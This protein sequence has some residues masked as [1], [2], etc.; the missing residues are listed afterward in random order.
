MRLHGRLPA[1]GLAVSVA[2]SLASCQTLGGSKGSPEDFIRLKEG[3]N[4]DRGR[5][6]MAISDNALDRVPEVMTSLTGRFDELWSK[7][8]AM[9]LLDREHLAIQIASARKTITSINQWVSS[10]DVDAVRSEVEKLNGILSEVD[11]LLDHTIRA[12]TADPSSGS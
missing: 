2:L 3:L 8:A 11:T 9:N 10:T 7:S 12:T 1:L 4:A 6:S 5:L